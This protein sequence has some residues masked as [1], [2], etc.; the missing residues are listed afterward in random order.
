MS[1]RDGT[2]HMPD[3]VKASGLLT[4]RTLPYRRPAKEEVAWRL[5]EEVV[6]RQT[7]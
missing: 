5:E 1:G 4:F 2:R 7:V 6:A 3:V